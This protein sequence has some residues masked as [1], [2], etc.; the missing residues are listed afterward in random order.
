MPGSSPRP[1]VLRRLAPGPVS[2]TAV[3]VLA[4]LM[5]LGD[6]FVLTSIQGA[7][8]AIERAQHP[9]AFWVRTSAL[10]L[11]VF[12]LSVLVAL[13]VARR[14]VGPALRT[15]AKVVV[16]ALL[17]VLAG[18]AVGTGEMVVSAAYDYQLQSAQGGMRM[19]M[20]VPVDP[21]SCT[22][23]CAAQQSQ[24]DLDQRAARLGSVLVLGSN[25]LLVGW[26]LALRG[27]RLE[28]TRPG[29]RRRPA[30]EGAIRTVWVSG[31][32]GSPSR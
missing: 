3:V 1:P 14:L 17:I 4:G 20:T 13:A 25:L 28:Q 11:P 21:S 8:G 5:A 2:W 29:G 16:A 31:P 23:V 19:D 6:G 26:V 12:V 10:M 24:F 27:G 9:F 30:T 18:S 7:V 22:G 15:P 32:L